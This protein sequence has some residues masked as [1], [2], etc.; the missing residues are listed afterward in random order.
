MWLQF[1]L[2][3]ALIIYAGNRLTRNAAIIAENTGVG[4]AWAGAL[5]L[6]LATSLPELVTTVRAVTIDSPDL[7]VGNIVGSC[8]YNL[9]L[10]FVI[11]LLEGRG[12]LSYVAGRRH[13]FL[14]SLSMITVSLAA[15]AMQRLIILPFGWIGAETLLIAFVYILGS[16]FLYRYEGKI[17]SSSLTN[18]NYVTKHKYTATSRAVLQFMTAAIVIVIAGVLLTDASELIAVQTGLGH[19]FVGSILLAISTSLPETVTTITAVRLGYL[20]MAVA[21]I[22]GANF[23]NLFIVFLADCLYLQSPLLHAVSSVHSLSAMMVV[24]L[25]ATVL[26]GLI[27]RSTRTV[28]RVGIDTLLVVV[29]YFIT[30]FLIFRSSVI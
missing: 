9:M 6:P 23:T 12:A 3:A 27:S 18:E 7:A 17:K 13:I 4:T 2:S 26:I 29:G 8:L 22:F 11:D 30:V 24:V 15:L 19:T 28:G 14:V 1:F 16:R 10:L 25:S 21:N 20:N 5:L